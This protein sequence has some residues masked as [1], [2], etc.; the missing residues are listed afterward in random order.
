MAF[1][2]WLS[3]FLCSFHLTVIICSLLLLPSTMLEDWVI[4]ATQMRRLLLKCH[5]H[6]HQQMLTALMFLSLPLWF[7]RPLPLLLFLKREYLPERH[8][9]DAAECSLSSS[10][11]NFFF[12]VS[13]ISIQSGVVNPVN[14]VRSRYFITA[15]P[16]GWLHCPPR[17]L[18]GRWCDTG[19]CPQ[20]TSH[21]TPSVSFSAWLWLV[22]S[23]IRL[24]WGSLISSILLFKQSN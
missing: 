18:P 13:V 19:C 1:C 5:C 2:A 7:T 9:G 3:T 24:Y 21:L 14:M 10:G 16:R 22:P 12:A 4:R 17:S 8:Q 11:V 6:L 15:H 23:K 20:H